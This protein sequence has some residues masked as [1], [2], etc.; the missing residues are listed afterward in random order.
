MGGN[1]KLAAAVCGFLF[2][3]TVAFAQTVPS[4]PAESIKPPTSKVPSPAFVS[5]PPKPKSPAKP[6]PVKKVI[7]K[8]LPGAPLVK[9]I[10][11]I[12]KIINQGGTLEAIA[13][14]IKQLI[15]NP[16]ING[17][18]IDD[19]DEV[20]IEPDPNLDP[21]NPV[22]PMVVSVVCAADEE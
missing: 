15:Y 5:P 7:K 4:A 8:P 6:V 17:L 12:T 21:K 19:D 2:F 11:V 14:A 10:N 22:C 9:D 13:A 1:K 3:A 16:V 20:L 18:L